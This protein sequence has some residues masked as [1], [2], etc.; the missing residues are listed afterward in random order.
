MGRAEVSVRSEVVLRNRVPGLGNVKRAH[1]L[2]R[3]VCIYP[4][5]GGRGDSQSL[6]AVVTY[7]VQGLCISLSTR[8]L[9]VISSS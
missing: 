8:E 2:G 1:Q 7:C 6:R 4:S 3:G 5:K 9:L